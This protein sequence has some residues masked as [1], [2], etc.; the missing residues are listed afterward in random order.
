MYN[1]D[2]E[3]RDAK[4]SIVLGRTTIAMTAETKED[5]T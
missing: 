1:R 2:G 4:K 5:E 3:A